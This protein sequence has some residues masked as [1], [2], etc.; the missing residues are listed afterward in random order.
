MEFDELLFPYAA[1]PRFLGDALL[2]RH[3]TTFVKGSLARTGAL[4]RYH[5][6]TKRRYPGS[7]VDAYPMY[8]GTSA[9]FKFGADEHDD[10][11]ESDDDPDSW[12]YSAGLSSSGE[13]P[14]ATHRSDWR[15]DTDLLLRAIPTKRHIASIVRSGWAP[16]F[17]PSRGNR[18]SRAGR[19][20]SHIVGS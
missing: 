4:N 13:Q 16:S 6:Y 2:S 19:G 12:E 9:A 8:G 15:P 14:A 1:V 5:R 18:F 7:G 10:D 11:G 20:R 17:R 3:D